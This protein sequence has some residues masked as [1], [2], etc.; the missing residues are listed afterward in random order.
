[1][2]LPEGLSVLPKYLNSFMK[3]MAAYVPPLAV[4]HHRG[5][6]T[7]TEYSSP[8]QAYRTPTGVI[9]GLAYSNNP[10]WLR[11]ITAGTGSTITRLG[12]TYTISNPRVIDADEAAHEL[13][14]PV[15]AMMTSI[16][17]DTFFQ[18]DLDQVK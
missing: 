4:I 6:T 13:P 5:R 16:G 3:P 7:G 2:P 15:A 8:V 14:R 18:C 10:H 17:V 9:V 1:M 11:N 12:K